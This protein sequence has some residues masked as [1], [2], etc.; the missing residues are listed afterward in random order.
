MQINWVI[1]YGVRIPEGWAMPED[2]GGRFVKGEDAV[3]RD[4]GPRPRAPMPVPDVEI[5]P[6][7]LRYVSGYI[8]PFH[9]QHPVTGKPTTEAARNARLKPL[10]TD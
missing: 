7:D 4:Q 5:D 9:F 1:P 8:F 6:A 10:G 2:I 3:P